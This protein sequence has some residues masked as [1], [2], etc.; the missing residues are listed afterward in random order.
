MLFPLLALMPATRLDWIVVFR[1]AAATI[2]EL[3]GVT[4]YIFLRPSWLSRTGDILSTVLVPWALI[5]TVVALL[6]LCVTGRWT[7]GEPGDGPV[8]RR[9]P[10]TRLRA[11]AD[12][13]GVAQRLTDLSRAA[14][15]RIPE[16][17]RP[18]TAGGRPPSSVAAA[19]STLSRPT[20]N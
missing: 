12:P 10:G 9:P 13:P 11:L 14:I 1:A 2:A 18:R 3:P 5:L 17:S 15:G 6:A 7:P 20:P 8:A 4:Y 16:N 19:T